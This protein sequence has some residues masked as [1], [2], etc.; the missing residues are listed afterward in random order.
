MKLSVYT[1]KELLSLLAGILLIAAGSVLAILMIA[2]IFFY[3]ADTEHP[4]VV[5]V[6]ICLVALLPGPAV[7]YLG[8]S[9]GWR[10]VLAAQSRNVL[11]FLTALPD[12]SDIPFPDSQQIPA[13]MQAGMLTSDNQPLERKYPCFMAR[14]F[15]KQGYFSRLLLPGDNIS[16]F[17][18]GTRILII[19]NPDHPLYLWIREEVLL[20]VQQ[21]FVTTEDVMSLLGY[22]KNKARRFSK[23]MNHAFSSASK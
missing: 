1:G 2:F 10:P 12:L 7:L 13:L 5:D 8:F 19:F 3:L 15:I 18:L 22:S 9:V 20:H 17:R 14:N 21:N 11:Y 6:L 23:Q 4:D 16:L